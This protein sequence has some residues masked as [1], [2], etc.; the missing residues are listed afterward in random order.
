MENGPIR[1]EATIAGQ[2]LV[3]ETG[4]VAKQAGGSV[5]A[6]L[7]DTRCF[8]AATA[9]NAREDIDFFPLVCDYREKPEAAGKIPGGFFK[10]EG[11]PSIKEILTMR[12][13]DRSIRPMFPDGYKSEVQVMTTALQYD[14]RNNPDILAMIAGFAA[15][16]VAGLPFETTLGAS[17]S[18]TSTAN[19]SPFPG[20]EERRDRRAASTWS[21]RATRTAVC[22]VESS[23]DQ[24]SEAEMIDAL[25]MAHETILEIVNL[26]DELKSPRAAASSRRFEAPGDRRG[27]CAPASSTSR[28][29]AQRDSHRGQARARRRV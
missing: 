14:G 19:S 28:R 20:D 11:R 27:V 26:V 16:R 4:L 15:V 29:P 1:V 6:T 7:G 13:I 12:M 18:R 2:R 24:L 17:A 5:I 3:L 25:E 9:G 21:W 23:A 22:M 8:A 10:R